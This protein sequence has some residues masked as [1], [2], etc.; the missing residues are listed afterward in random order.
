[1]YVLVDDV[2]CV[3]IHGY[4]YVGERYAMYCTAMARIRRLTSQRTGKPVASPL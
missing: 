4:S 3:D 1:M 2:L